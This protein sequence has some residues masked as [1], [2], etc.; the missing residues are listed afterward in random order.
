MNAN[1][2]LTQNVK[3]SPLFSQ[4]LMR[5]VCRAYAISTVTEVGCIRA[6]IQ[7]E[8][9]TWSQWPMNVS[10]RACTLSKTSAM[11]R[12]FKHICIVTICV[13]CPLICIL[14][15][16]K[17]DSFR[18][19]QAQINFAVDI[20]PFVFKGACLQDGDNPRQRDL[21]FVSCKHRGCMSAFPQG[22]T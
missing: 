13:G 8:K 7:M 9:T 3:Q 21:N 4:A 6:Y 18:S 15:H 10:Y 22:L 16:A 14:P 5:H 1:A 2:S 11:H 20:C 17:N 12:T 19:W